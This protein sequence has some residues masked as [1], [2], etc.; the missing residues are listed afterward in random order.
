MFDN[1]AVE[2]SLSFLLLPWA[3]HTVPKR[4]HRISAGSLMVSA[5]SGTHLAADG[6][7]TPSASPLRKVGIRA[8]GTC[9]RRNLKPARETET[10]EG[11]AHQ[12]LLQSGTPTGSG[13][14]GPGDPPTFFVFINPASS[15]L[16]PVG[17]LGTRRAETAALWTHQKP[18]HDSNPTQAPCAEPQ[19]MK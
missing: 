14:M 16:E 1:I 17:V 13:W 6:A 5:L 15:L 11:P 10:T 4:S 7:H 19:E 9:S 18:P 3:T 12:E 8:G 2:K